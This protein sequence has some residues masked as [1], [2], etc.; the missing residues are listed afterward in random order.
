MK[1]KIIL[2]TG[3]TAVALTACNKITGGGWMIDESDGDRVSFGFTARETEDPSGDCDFSSGPSCVEA[4]G[5][6]TLIDHGDVSDVRQIWRGTFEGTWTGQ[7]PFACE[8]TA[9]TPCASTFDGFATMNGDEYLVRI[10]VTDNG[11]GSGAINDF[12][13]VFLSPVGGGDL[14]VYIGEIGG[15]NLQ[16]HV[17]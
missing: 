16:V 9:E 5:K 15:G 17:D 13:K 11:E 4:K 14:I 3:L 6:L 8:D 1:L 2:L 7:A 10:E 12:L